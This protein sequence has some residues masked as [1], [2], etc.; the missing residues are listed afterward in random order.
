MIGRSTGVWNGI[1]KG[2]DRA[3]ASLDGIDDRGGP[4][5][6]RARREAP[7]NP[8]LSSV[9]L[10]IGQPPAGAGLGNG[11]A[12]GLARTDP[13]PGG[14]F[15]HIA[16]LAARLA[17]A[18]IGVISNERVHQAWS[19]PALHLG[20]PQSGR[21]RD[22][23]RHLEGSP[24]AAVIPDAKQDP[25]LWH[26]PDVAGAPHLRF[27]ASVPLI[28]A[29]GA[30][31][32]VLCVM[33]VRPRP[34]LSDEHADA[35]TDLATLAAAM[36]ERSLEAEAQARSSRGTA[37]TE[38]MDAAVIRAQSCELALA[39]ML[40][41]LCQHH[42]ATAG[43]VGK[44]AGSSRVLQEVC[45]YNDEAGAGDYFAR[46]AGL[47]IPPDTSQAALA[48]DNGTPRTLV[49]SRSRRR[50]LCPCARRHGRRTRLAR[51]HARRGDPP[52]A[53]PG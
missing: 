5:G 6:F 42:G 33:D 12:P 15:L 24:A 3:G 41:G 48:I 30:S 43:F 10:G 20:P 46:T 2:R 45:H 9:S 50:R 16:R 51:R 47:S 1:E 34:R 25:R 37:R 8:P 29:R 13:A 39:S 52:R 17:R 14:D 27:V 11:L 49:F 26:S 19:D 40:V 32:G 4:D 18:P 22:I 53:A 21:L 31:L 36:L 44:L 23:C 38:K 35:L 28:G 7:P